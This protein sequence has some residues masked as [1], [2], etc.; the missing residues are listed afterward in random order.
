MQGHSNKAI[1]REL[2]FSE[3][4]VAQHLKAV[5][6]KLGVVSRATAIAMATQRGLL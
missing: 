1:G 5:F 6:D 2:S 3:H 4:T